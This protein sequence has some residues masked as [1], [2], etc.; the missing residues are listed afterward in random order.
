VRLSSRSG[1]M[2]T[3]TTQA[4]ARAA[5]WTLQPLIDERVTLVAYCRNT[6]NQVLGLEAA[7]PAR[8]GHDCRS[9]P[10]A[11]L[12]EMQGEGDRD[13]LLA[14]HA[15]GRISGPRT[16]LITGVE[17]VGKPWRRR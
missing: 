13:N 12:L 15:A 3:G 17:L 10:A 6:H 9:R 16:G 5:V 11:S 4:S 8:A 7:R 2:P 1:A 14:N